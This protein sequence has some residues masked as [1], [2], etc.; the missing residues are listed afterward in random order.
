MADILMRPHHLLCTQAFRGMGYSKEFTENMAAL[1]KMMKEDDDFTLEL[2]SGT[3]HICRACPNKIGEN[4][5]KD[6][7][8]V[9][10]FDKKI[11]E[12]FGLEYGKKYNYKE[13]TE[14]IDSNLDENRLFLICGNCSWY[15]KSRC[16][17]YIL[18]NVH[19]NQN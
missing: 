8:K 2:V 11:K 13:L 18:Q 19:L 16:R 3:D 17:D 1:V 9:L 4:V 12:M 14:K 6:D 5:C 15:E 10:L 7:E